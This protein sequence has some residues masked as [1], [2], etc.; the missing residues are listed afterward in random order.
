MEDC[1]LNDKIICTID[2]G[3]SLNKNIVHVHVTNTLTV[4][5]L[6]FSF[7]NRYAAYLVFSLRQ[8]CLSST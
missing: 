2:K 4:N 5:V 6:K 8:F 3:N 7:S 1:N